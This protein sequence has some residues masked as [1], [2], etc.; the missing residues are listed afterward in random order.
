M[1]VASIKPDE[2]IITTSLGRCFS[3]AGTPHQLAYLIDELVNGYG[4]NFVQFALPRGDD[5]SI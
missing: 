1:I 2:V 3:V 4:S 5:H